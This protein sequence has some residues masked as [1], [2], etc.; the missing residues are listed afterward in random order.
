MYANDFKNFGQSEGERGFH[1]P[2]EDLVEEAEGF[3]AYIC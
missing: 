3:I 2:I 1:P